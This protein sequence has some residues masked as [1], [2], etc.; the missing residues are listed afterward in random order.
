VRARIKRDR[1]DRLPALD[2]EVHLALAAPGGQ[3]GGARLGGLRP[4][5]NDYADINGTHP[6]FWAIMQSTR[7]P[8]H[9]HDPIHAPA[10]GW[11]YA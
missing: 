10:G 2:D 6:R 11:G 1:E 8:A 4:L 5:Q 9:F 7:Q 3:V